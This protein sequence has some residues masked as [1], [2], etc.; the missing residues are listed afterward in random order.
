ML[1]QVYPLYIKEDAVTDDMRDVLRQYTASGYQD[2]NISL[3]VNYN[4]DWVYVNKLRSLIRGLW[5]LNLLTTYYRGV[6][7]TDTEVNFYQENINESYYTTSFYSFSSDRLSA[8]PGNALII[9]RVRPQHRLNIANVERWSSYAHERETILA[10]G[11][12]L[13]INSTERINEKWE[14]ELELIGND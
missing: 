1:R 14:I 9:L 5:Q 10:I 6:N 3:L 13:K 2:T 7:L 12:R 4:I 8:F 11:S